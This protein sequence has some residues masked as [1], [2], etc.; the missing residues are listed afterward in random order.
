MGDINEGSNFNSRV[1]EPTLREMASAIDSLKELIKERIEATEQRIE[2]HVNALEDVLTARK[3]YHDERYKV[4]KE[5]SINVEIRIRSELKSLE[6]RV[7]TYL[8]ALKEEIKL[9]FHNAEMYASSAREFAEK[10]VLKAE[11]S[12]DKRFESVNEF[13]ST[14]S[15]QAGTF[16]PRKETESLV[17]QN[18]N[19]IDSLK[20]DI[21][22]QRDETR[23]DLAASIASLKNDIQS[24][25]ETRSAAEA[26]QIQNKEGTLHGQWLFGVIIAVLGLGFSV[27]VWILTHLAP[28]TTV[29]TI[30]PLK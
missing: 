23:N 18:R 4:L 8:A 26:G 30:G 7:N 24:L 5:E 29:P 16:M 20:R 22:A 15:D 19:L 28:I 1:N 21:Q 10:A 9:A 14:L 12:A 13:R 17:L 27:V 3:N 11:I 6:D 25:R 2:Q